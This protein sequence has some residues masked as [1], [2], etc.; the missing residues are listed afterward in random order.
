V[1]AV[2]GGTGC[3]GVNVGINLGVAAGPSIPDHLHVHVVP[4]FRGDTNFMT[5]TA[6]TRVLPVTLR[7]SWERIRGA[8]PA[9]TGSDTAPGAEGP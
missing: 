2:R 9:G 5:A 1:V 8:W 7:E 4:R 6:N 3:Q